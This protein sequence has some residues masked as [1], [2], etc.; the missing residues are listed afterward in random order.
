MTTSV[1]GKLLMPPHHEARAHTV[2]TLCRLL[3]GLETLPSQVAGGGL[4]QHLFDVAA[5]LADG[6]PD[7][8]RLHCAKSV[9][10]VPGMMPTLHTSSDFRLYY[11]FSIPPPTVMDGVMLAHRDK[12][13]VPH[14][15]ASRGMGAMYGIRP[16]P[17]ERLSPYVIRRWELLSEPT[18]NVGVNDTSLNLSLFQAI[19]I[20]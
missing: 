20:H 2:L 19:R 15:S 7:D 3:L 16:L 9:L 12:A 17:H 11:I 5:V 18:P 10:V 4:L 13:A 6:L 14:S 8:L 1:Q